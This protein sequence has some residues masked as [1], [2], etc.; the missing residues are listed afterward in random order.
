[1]QERQ[2]I[3]DVE[4]IALLLNRGRAMYLLPFRRAPCTVAQAARSCGVKPNHMA[5]WVGRFVEVGLLTPAGTHLPGRRG[6]TYQA[7]ARE[8]ILL[9]GAG[10]TAEE[11]MGQCY[12]EGWRSLERA[13]A[14]DTQRTASCWALR[15]FLHGD[16]WLDFQKVPVEILNG[17]STISGGQALNLWMTAHYDRATLSEL[18]AELEDVFA[19]YSRRAVRDSPDVPRSIFHIAL[20]RDPSR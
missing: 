1:M 4:V 11:I 17:T 18:R 2:V 19:R 7:A 14:E 9:P 10:Y 6:Q 16:R 15:L 3:R 12:G 13:V 20:V 8:F 5:Y